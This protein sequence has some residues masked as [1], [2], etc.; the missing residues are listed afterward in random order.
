MRPEIFGQSLF[1]V[2]ARLERSEIV[3]EDL[4]RLAKSLLDGVDGKKESIQGTVEIDF[5]IEEFHAELIE[6]A[7]TAGLRPF[8]SE[9]L[10]HVG[11][12]QGQ[13][14]R[15]IELVFKNKTIDPGGE[16]RPKSIVLVSFSLQIEC[17]FADNVGAFADG[18]MEKPRFLE[19]RRVD[20][21]AAIESAFVH[22]DF[23]EPGKDFLFLAEVIRRPAWFLDLII[24][25]I[26]PPEKHTKT[27][28]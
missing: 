12:T 6:F 20:S 8:I 3:D 22:E 16:L 1:V 11:I 21:L 10:S 23:L 26:F 18:T 2:F 27:S 24:G 28:N 15:C 19:N 9:D 14:R 25:H 5:A 17:L 13:V 4:D 7:K